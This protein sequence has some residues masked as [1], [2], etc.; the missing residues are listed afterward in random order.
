MI[1]SEHFRNWA[2]R[3]EVK[4]FQF[5]LTITAYHGKVLS[6]IKRFEVRVDGVEYPESDITFVLRGKT[7]T[8]MQRS[9]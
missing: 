5:G 6:E 8:M 4:G 3:G 2:E 9:N 1:R 7:Y